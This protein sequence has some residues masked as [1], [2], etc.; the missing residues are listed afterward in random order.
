[1]NETA[2]VRA[3][4]YMDQSWA[5]MIRRIQNLIPDSDSFVWSTYVCEGFNVNTEYLVVNFLVTIGH[6]LPWGILA[7][8]MMKS[9]E[10]AA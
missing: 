10:V 2:G 3:I 1:M 6:I 5:W 7:Y 4:G 9:R 8:Y